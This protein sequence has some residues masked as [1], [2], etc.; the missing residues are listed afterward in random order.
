MYNKQYAFQYG[1]IPIHQVVLRGQCE[2]HSQ[3]PA[4]VSQDSKPKLIQDNALTGEIP[5]EIF[6]F[7]KENNGNYAYYQ[8]EKNLTSLNYCLHEKILI[9]PNYRLQIFSCYLRLRAL[10][11]LEC[12]HFLF[13]AE[14]HFSSVYFDPISILVLTFLFYRFQSLNKKKSFI[15]VL[16]VSHLI[17]ISY[18]TNGVYCWH[19]KC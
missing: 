19:S 4:D 12:Q 14:M 17:K 5:L 16:T 7:S 2:L 8:H 10:H 9:S 1:Q 15:L 3:I 6:K 11:L 13:L 18:M